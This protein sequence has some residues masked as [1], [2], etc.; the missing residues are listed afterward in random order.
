MLFIRRFWWDR[1]DLVQNQGKCGF[2]EYEL[3]V[4]LYLVVLITVNVC[5]RKCVTIK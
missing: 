3:H 4:S 2:R 1:N 5:H